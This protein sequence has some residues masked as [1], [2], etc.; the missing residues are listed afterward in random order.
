MNFGS[1]SPFIVIPQ[2]KFYVPSPWGAPHVPLLVTASQGGAHVSLFITLD[3]LACFIFS[4]NM[5]SCGIF[6]VCL[7][8]STQNCVCD[9]HIVYLCE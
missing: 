3:S 7:A 4:I 8:S 9:I 6:S 2:T 1:W 5:E